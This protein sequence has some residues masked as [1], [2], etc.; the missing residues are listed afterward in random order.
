MNALKRSK[1]MPKFDKDCVG[2]CSDSMIRTG[3]CNCH[4]TTSSV[5]NKTFFKPFF[6]YNFWITV[7]I[8]CFIASFITHLNLVVGLTIIVGVWI[9]FQY[10]KKN[11]QSSFQ[12][13]R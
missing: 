8:F 6:Q 5:N 1:V 9:Y 12:R 11:G 7:M 10:F 2:P 13:K 3:F 4:K